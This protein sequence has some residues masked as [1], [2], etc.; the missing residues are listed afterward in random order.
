MRRSFCGWIRRGRRTEEGYTCGRVRWFE[1]RCL[2]VGFTA[3]VGIIGIPELLALG[4]GMGILE[5]AF[6]RARAV[7]F[8]FSFH[9]S[10]HLIGHEGVTFLFGISAGIMGW[11]GECFGVLGLG[12]A[13][14]GDGWIIW[15]C[16]G[17]TRIFEI[18]SGLRSG[19]LRI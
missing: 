8:P 1:G 19:D 16:L 10:P 9:I 2:G 12:R 11:A 3:R 4:F 7:L 13:G 5:E 17:L 15:E 18:F 14:I 6:L